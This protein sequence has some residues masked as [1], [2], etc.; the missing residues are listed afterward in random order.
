MRERGQLL[1]LVGAAGAG[2]DTLAGYLRLYGYRRVAFADK[3]KTLALAI[4][5]CIHD[6]VLG[7]THLERIVNVEDWEKAKLYTEV[8]EF[9]QTL[10]LGAREVLGPNVWV[11]AALRG[12]P[13]SLEAGRSVVFT[14]VRFPNEV[15]RIRELGGVICKVTR[16]G[17]KRVNAHPSE[18]LAWDDSQEWEY[19]VVNDS[20]QAT[21]MRRAEK[22]R[23]ALERG[24]HL[25]QSAAVH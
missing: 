6:P 12:V 20:T 2:K 19:E 21:L 25:R 15:A 7:I 8:R 5:P 22:L 14:D 23:K 3:L 24:D 16:P 10:G 9:L 4:N 11:D 17:I 13:A 18:D 1:G